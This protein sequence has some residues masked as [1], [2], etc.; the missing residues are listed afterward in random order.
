MP[1]YY[2]VIKGSVGPFGTGE[3]ITEERINIKRF[4][5]IER[6]VK[7]GVVEKASAAESKAAETP[8]N[9]PEARAELVTGAPLPLAVP[10]EEVE[11]SNATRRS[12]SKSSDKK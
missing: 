9:S 1:T 5:G 4:G 10:V 11:P 6:L 7:K 3:V 2:K 8:E 12:S